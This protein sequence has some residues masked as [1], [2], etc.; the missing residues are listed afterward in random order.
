M[1]EQQSIKEKIKEE[2]V[3]CATD[4]VYFMKKYYMIQHPLKGRQF[5]NLYPFQEKVLKLFQK[6]D[7]SVINKSS[8]SSTDPA[9]TWLSKDSEGREPKSV[10]DS[11]RPM[12][13]ARRNSPEVIDRE[14]ISLDR[15]PLIL[16]AWSFGRPWKDCRF[17]TPITL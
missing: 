8:G 3:K 1:S 2:F 13:I 11:H 12:P 4:P 10:T 14:Q 17:K 15:V 5:F 16:K 9:C 7:Y 6:H